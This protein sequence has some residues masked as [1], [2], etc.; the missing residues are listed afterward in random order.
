MGSLDLHTA[1]AMEWRVGGQRNTA[2]FERL[3]LERNLRLTSFGARVFLIAGLVG[4]IPVA[5]LAG[6]QAAP[7]APNS[8]A[9]GHSVVVIGPNSPMFDTLLE[10]WFP[11]VTSVNYFNQLK[12]LLAIVHNNT[13]RVVKA[14]VVRWTI[15]DADGSTSTATLPV[16]WEPPPGDPRLSGTLT[17]LGPAG[18][19]LGTQLVSPFFHWP[20]R[21]LP[22]LLKINAAMI[23][24]QAANT[25][26]LV[27][28]VQSATQIR[29]T[30]DGAIFGDGMFIG[31]D[32]SK[33]YEHFQAVQH[34]EVDEGTWM[35]NLL[36]GSPSTDEIM[37]QL[38][39]QVYRGWGAAA[40]NF[41]TAAK[42]QQAN[43]MLSV[44]QTG[45]RAK[46]QA[47]ATQ[48]VNAKRMTLQRP[49]AH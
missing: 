3:G 30:L 44:L 34:A 48:I 28:S 16:M 27:S 31:P 47:F 14:Y 2:R 43:R 39:Q 37:T 7:P 40:D 32:T 45:E 8:Y 36:Q 17:V 11:G 4:L 9:L 42:G 18:T 46:L 21:A 35:S 41:Y 10:R 20:R 25:N 38:N 24:F 13:K 33:L 1:L 15:T 19:G 29:T 5:V 49:A 12:P 6:A 22:G 26:A 23:S